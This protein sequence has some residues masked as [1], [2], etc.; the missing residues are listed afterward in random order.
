MRP[1]SARTAEC[2][3]FLICVATA[4]ANTLPQPGNWAFKVQTD[5][6]NIPAEMHLNF[7]PIDFERC[8]TPDQI[9]TPAGF[10]AQK[11]PAME[12][13]CTHP[14]WQM[15]DGTFDYTFICDEGK[16]LTASATGTYSAKRVVLTMISKPTPVVRDIDTIKH[17]ITAE[18]KGPCKP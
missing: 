8:V 6:S 15:Q 7:P 10:G 1:S 3:V 2:V 17:R 5:L 13:R 12:A 14:T 16:T 18:H 4:Q 11:S 9:L